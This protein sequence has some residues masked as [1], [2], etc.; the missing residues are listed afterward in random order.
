VRTAEVHHTTTDHA[1]PQ[2]IRTHCPE[3]LR[4][5]VVIASRVSDS[6]PSGGR[7]APP[8]REYEIPLN[9]GSEF[10]QWISE[11]PMGIGSGAGVDR[12]ASLVVCP[13]VE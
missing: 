6:R 8:E 9:S 12:A 11:T 2:Q 13:P 10:G 4:R 3:I 1:D 7:A 5:I